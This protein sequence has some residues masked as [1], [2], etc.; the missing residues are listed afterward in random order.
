MAYYMPI[1]LFITNCLVINKYIGMNNAFN[2]IKI[3]SIIIS[4]LI[5]FNLTLQGCQYEDSI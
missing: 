4:S 3:L 2:T 1:Y 5:A